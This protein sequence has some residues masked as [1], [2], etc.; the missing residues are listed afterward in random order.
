V[1]SGGG[2]LGFSNGNMSNP[3][4]YLGAVGGFSFRLDDSYSEI[5]PTTA[6]A[7][8]GITD[9]LDVCCWH[10]TFLTY[11][12]FLEVL[13]TV[14]GD[15]SFNGEAAA[16]GGRQVIITPGGSGPTDAAAPPP[17]VT[18]TV[19]KAVTGNAPDL[20]YGFMLDCFGVDESFT[21]GAGESRSI[22]M[23][24]STRCTL[25]E[26]GDGGAESTSGLFSGQLIGTNTSVT[27]TNTFPEVPEVMG[28]A[29]TKVRT[30]PSPAAV[31]EA[32]TFDISVTFFGELHN[33]ELADDFDPDVLQFDGAT[34]GG[35]ALDCVVVA[36]MP[37]GKS[38]AVCDLGTATG[39]FTVQTHYTALEGTTPG[40]TVSAAT[41]VNDQDG[42]G[43]DPPTTTGP[44]SASVEVVEV[45][46]LPPLG[47]GPT[48][49]G[50]ILWATVGA[51]LTLIVGARYVVVRRQRIDR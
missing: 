50:W 19:T 27:V 41:V 5:L 16:I 23:P 49:S 28:T 51:V 42:P 20:T 4:G 26:P 9:A 2:L 48:T 29:I 43:G 10:D 46:A 33:A 47:D 7:A 30:T 6:G 35:A 44:A 15:E 22:S 18:L 14:D 1:N 17:P 11:P 3:Y 21:L 45:L 37:P 39:S 36:N 24:A 31:G 13:A 25:T 12:S 40:Q 8:I 38:S 32:V 34:F